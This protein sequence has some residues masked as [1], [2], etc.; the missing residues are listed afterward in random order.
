M[1][2]TSNTGRAVIYAR[3]STDGQ[4][5]SLSIGAQLDLCRQFGQRI[6][7]E[8]IAEFT[9]VGSGGTDERAGLQK[10]M[11]F[12]TD[13][14]NGA[15]TLIVYDLSRFTRDPEH[16][17]DYYGTLKRSGVQLQSVIEPHRGDEMS[18][19]FYS[20]ITIFN[21]V[22]LPRIARLTRRGQFQATNNGYYVGV[23][24]PFAYQKY[25][26]WDGKNR[27]AKLE[28]NP[29]TW[30]H[31]RRLWDLMLEDR[32]S[33]ETAIILNSEGIR[34]SEGREWTGDAVLE[35]ARNEVYKGDVVRGKNSKSKYLDKKERA[36]G[37][38]A[39]VAM[40]TQ[41]EFDKVQ[42]LIARRTF[43]SSSPRSHSSPS[44]FSGRAFC[45]KCGE[46]MHLHTNTNGKVKLICR[47]K[48]RLKAQAC[49]K[50]NLDLNELQEAV[51]ENLLGHVLTP[52][53]YG[54]QVRL[55]GQRHQAVVAEEKKKDTAIRKRI[56]E[57]GVSVKNLMGQ[58]EAHGPQPDVNERLDE[59]REER[60]SLEAELKA[61]EERVKNRAIFVNEPERI[62]A[63]AIDKRTY[64]EA[65]DPHKVRQLMKI[66]VRRLDIDDETV[67]IEY[68]IPIPQ[69]DGDPIRSETIFLRDTKCVSEGSMGIDPGNVGTTVSSTRFPRRRGDRPDNPADGR[70]SGWVPPQARG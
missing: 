32:S 47:R 1:Q 36:R 23:K 43:A 18:D 70:G 34:T 56:T 57:T 4:D 22:L 2:M 10:M 6:G 35:V 7:K 60:L 58:I 19:L 20:I 66:F 64:L 14:K 42:E 54:E 49:N 21:S 41:E 11:P 61:G 39:H 25:Y 37:E 55:V 31:G 29:K 9:D 24:P 16:F 3:M 53:F 15:D 50:E 48:R 52:D 65:R 8:I 44:M 5:H 51:V 13:K 30:N 63:N 59:L 69:E 68:E 45:A 62:I 17:F 28:P 26:V 40:V 67:R 38:N 27:H 12:V 46:P 33:T